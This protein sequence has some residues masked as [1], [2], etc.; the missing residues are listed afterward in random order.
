MARDPG[1][2]RS[3]AKHHPVS[4]FMG[5]AWKPGTVAQSSVD[6]CVIALVSERRTVVCYDARNIRER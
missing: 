5:A 1:R 2:F 6:R 4:V 3:Y